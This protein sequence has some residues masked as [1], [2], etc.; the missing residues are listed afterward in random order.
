MLHYCR[1]KSG[2][3][4]A[5]LSFLISCQTADV[6]T[7]SKVLERRPS[8][9]VSDRS[10]T[11]CLLSEEEARGK[12]NPFNSGMPVRFF[13][14]NEFTTSESRATWD[15][16]KFS[17]PRH[18]DPAAYRYLVHTVDN[19]GIK[20]TA[21]SS[22]D[23]IEKMA[24]NPCSSISA[25]L[26]SHVK[27][28]T[29][30]T[31]GFILSSPAENILFSGPKDLSSFVLNNNTD[32]VVFNSALNQFFGSYETGPFLSADELLRLTNPKKY[33]EVLIQNK[34]R[35][36]IRINGIFVVDSPD[37]GYGTA[38]ERSRL[39]DE[40]KKLAEEKNLPLVHFRKP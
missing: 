33:N 6:T 28:A 5:T 12:V 13:D 20:Y 3:G 16:L 37:S 1:L 38:Q 34:V 30:G 11:G 7:S 36:G 40:L 18:H 8:N 25:S 27:R 35:T 19:F 29:F 4:L 24:E 21:H 32:P 9:A 17:D 2:V 14:R 15:P 22:F 39:L 26:V 10:Q 31:V 23:F